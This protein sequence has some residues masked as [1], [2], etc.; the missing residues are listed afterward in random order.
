M[1]FIVPGA[2]LGK[3]YPRGTS[4]QKR[5]RNDK[6]S[7][8]IA[9]I[10]SEIEEADGIRQYGYSKDHKPNPGSDGAVLRRFRF[11]WLLLLRETPM[12]NHATGFEKKILKDLNC[13]LLFAPMR[14]S[15]LWR[16]GCQ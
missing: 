10:A 1:T 16:T 12:S 13:R 4:R 11:P 7:I 8:M 9:P 2:W 3:P 5:E 15:H 14:G 6:I